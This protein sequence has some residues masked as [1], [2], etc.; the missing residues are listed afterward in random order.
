MNLHNQEPFT[1]TEG[2]VDTGRMHL[3]Y[4]ECGNPD[5]FPLLALHGWLDNAATFARIAPLLD[6]TKI[7]FI[8]LDLP[9][10]GYSEHR[11]NGD[12]YH[13]LEYVVECEA[14]ARALNIRQ[15]DILG[16]SLGGVIGMLWAA[17]APATIR[18]LALIDSLG[19]FAG[20]ESKVAANFQ[21]ALEKTLSTTT[22]KKP[23]Y[24]SV[25]EAITA[26]MSGIG[27][28][29]REAA[30]YLVARGLKKISEGFTWRSDAR[31][32]HPSLVRFTE[33][34]IQG[35]LKGVEAEVLCILA[36]KGFIAVN[37]KGLGRLNF[38]KNKRHCILQG[39]H[40][41]HLDDAPQAVADELNRFFW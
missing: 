16:H 33:G 28:I 2:K 41:L 3:A 38:L 26:R 32:T 18:K 29:S 20:K 10:H 13:L 24:P 23:V 15:F 40:H 9:G 37:E 36:S 11:P 27:N 14:F 39:G 30:G 1:F 17:G 35:F 34:Q 21:E 19:P 25:E 5:G 22:P 7:R 12:I 8:A 6:L 4:I 31:L